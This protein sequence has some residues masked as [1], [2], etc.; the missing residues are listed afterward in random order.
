ML[1]AF[2]F[3][4]DDLDGWVDL[5]LSTGT[6]GLVRAALAGL[7]LAGLGR[8]HPWAMLVGIGGNLLH[9]I[10]NYNFNLVLK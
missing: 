5:D 10:R 3:L 7:L 6:E 9:E 8:G 2:E 1:H 4:G